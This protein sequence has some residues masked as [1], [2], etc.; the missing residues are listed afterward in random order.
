VTDSL[1]NRV[2]PLEIRRAAMDLLARRE[3]SFHE[4]AA[5]LSRKFCSA[6]HKPDNIFTQDQ[7]S[8]GDQVDSEHSGRLLDRQTLDEM[9][10]EQLTQLASEN[11][12]SDQRFV[13]SFINS[14]KAQ[15]KGPLRIRLELQQ[16]QLSS[17]LIEQHLDV[18]D[19]HWLVLA[20]HIYLKKFGH[21]PAK[22]HQEKA[23]RF[24]FMQYR[25]FSP[26]LLRTL[27]K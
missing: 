11:L 15:G 25:G 1:I 17:D 27:I 19:E 23:K 26:D 9:I 8:I 22:N 7:T 10:V 14:R 3:H 6:V 18:A 16:K 20:E 12:Q 24:R 5:K 13:E 21:K 4:L 2:K